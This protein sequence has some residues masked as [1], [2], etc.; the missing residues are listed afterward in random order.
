MPE[1]KKQTKPL[2]RERL[3]QTSAREQAIIKEEARKLFERRREELIEELR[4]LIRISNSVSRDREIY[5]LLPSGRKL[6]SIRFSQIVGD[7]FDLHSLWVGKENYNL[8][9]SHI[10]RKLGI[11]ELL[12][13]E[14]LKIANKKGIKHIEL[15]CDPELY[16]FYK[17]FGFRIRKIITRRHGK[18]T[19]LL[20][21]DT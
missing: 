11:G 18:D 12:I 4:K 10:L 17:Q 21:L 8:N 1:I 15:D 16:N 19:Y 20:Y 6:A 3:K 7:R 13:E 5:I 9:D 2:T 14:A